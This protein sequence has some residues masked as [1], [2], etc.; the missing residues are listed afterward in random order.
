V[1]QILARR[2]SRIEDI[3]YL[4]SLVQRSHHL[5]V[6]KAARA[7]LAMLRRKFSA[8]LDRA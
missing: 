5:D 8:E 6:R 2:L 3:A 4:E 7:Q 1:G